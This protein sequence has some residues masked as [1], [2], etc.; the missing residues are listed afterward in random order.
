MDEKRNQTE[1]FDQPDINVKRTDFDLSF[2]N[3]M[4]LNFN[5][6][7]PILCQKT[8]PGDSWHIKSDVF[9]RWLAMQAPV[10]SEYALKFNSAYV[11]N[12]LIYGGWQQFIGA[13]DDQAA[14]YLLDE[15]ANAIGG[16]N[17]GLDHELPHFTS[18]DIA[19]YPMHK[20]VHPTS[21]EQLG[22]HQHR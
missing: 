14:Q 16:G 4:T 11:A 10:F 20:V 2:P 13:G 18:W 8:M 21:I 19:T 9:S 1:L 7:V 5:K 17:H 12:N 22:H 6:M 3:K 15:Q